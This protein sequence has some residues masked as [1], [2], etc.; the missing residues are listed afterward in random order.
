MEE[1]ELVPVD[2]D[3]PQERRRF[4]DFVNANYRSELPLEESAVADKRFHFYWAREKG[5]GAEVGSTGFMAKTRYLAETI[6]TMIHPAY[7]GRGLG[8]RLSQLIEEEVRRR[9]FTKIMTTIY[10]TNLPMV[11]IKLK[12]GYLFE[13]FHRDHDKPGLH[14]YSMGKF[15]G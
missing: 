11:F 6:K 14:E 4:V 1:I 2:R 10:V 8:E 3:N 12:Q 15:I 7:R 9:G 13:G 5:G